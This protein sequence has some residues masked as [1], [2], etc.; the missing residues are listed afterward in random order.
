MRHHIQ[1]GAEQK[2]YILEL[3]EDILMDLMAKH[4]P[5]EK[6]QDEWD[7][8]GFRISAGNQ[9][10]LDISALGVN[11]RDLPYDELATQLGERIKKRYEDK[12][13][14]IGPEYMRYQERMIMLQVLDV[15]W[16]DHL[17]AMDHLKEGIGLRG[18]GQRDPLNEYKKESFDLFQEMKD[19]V[20]DDIVQQLFRYE[21]MTDE[22]AAEQRRRPEMKVPKI[23][24]SAPP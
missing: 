6:S 20:E 7:V 19:R 9:F 11:I 15:Q 16:K 24:L 21:P 8:D 4:T 23:E 17:W 1:E 13:K 10:G 3:A 22:Q 14:R 18:Y 2:E 5:R 12:E